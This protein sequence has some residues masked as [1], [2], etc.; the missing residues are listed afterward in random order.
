[1]KNLALIVGLVLCASNTLWAAKNQGLMRGGF[2]FLY[3]DANDFVNG[4]QL[5]ANHATA[6]GTRYTKNKESNSQLGAPS[7]IWANGKA[8]FGAYVARVGSKLDSAVDS[9]DS[10]GFAGGIGFAQE[11]VNVGFTYDRS[12]DNGQTNDGVLAGQMNIHLGKSDG[13][14]IGA[15]YSTTVGGDT[16]AKVKT[17]SGA[18]GYR[19]NPHNYLEGVYTIDNMDD[20]GNFNT[21][22]GALRVG[23]QAFYVSGA[24]SKTKLTT[25]TVDSARGRLGLVVNAFDLYLEY[26]KVLETD[27]VAGSTTYGGAMRLAF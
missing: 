26:S 27:L 23:G 21:I 17:A 13:F 10:V 5:S 6:I 2:G 1:M 4:G 8:G 20:G 25:I 18:L 14:S 24:F 7:F 22:T 3:A 11:K 9:A 16:A 19:F 12:I 15:E